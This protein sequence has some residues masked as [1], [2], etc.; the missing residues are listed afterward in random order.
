MAQLSS[1]AHSW[2]ACTGASW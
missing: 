1:E 2:T